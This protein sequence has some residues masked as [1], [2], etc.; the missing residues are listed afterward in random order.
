MLHS[1][2]YLNGAVSI[3][4]AK[5]PHL[6]DEIF[7]CHSPFSAEILVIIINWKKNWDIKSIVVLLIIGWYS[8]CK[9]PQ[10]HISI[11]TQNNQMLYEDRKVFSRMKKCT[12]FTWLPCTEISKQCHK[13]S[14]E[15]RIKDYFFHWHSMV[16]I[17]EKMLYNYYTTILVFYMMQKKIV[18]HNNKVMIKILLRWQKWEIEFRFKKKSLLFCIIHVSKYKWC[19]HNLKKKPN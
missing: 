3:L 6:Y 17:E 14:V 15:L 11:K 1:K 7:K 2:T 4:K 10:Y 16:A 12:F 9:I 18:S 13:H 5:I 8:F 19:C